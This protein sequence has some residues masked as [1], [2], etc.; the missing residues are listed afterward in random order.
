MS[1]ILRDVKKAMESSKEKDSF[2][3]LRKI[4][5][6]RRNIIVIDPISLQAIKAK[7]PEKTKGK[8]IDLN[9]KIKKED[10]LKLFHKKDCPEGTI[11]LQSNGKCAKPKVC[12]DGK[13]LNL[14][15]N[16]CIKKK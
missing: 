15:T 4:P 12:P 11:R 14:K 16:R 13:V 6:P 3:K 8:F 10:L 5:S 1:F 2:Y 9:K 7:T